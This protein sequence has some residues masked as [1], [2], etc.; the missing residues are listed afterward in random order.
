MSQIERTLTLKR[1][2]TALS[3]CLWRGQLRLGHGVTTRLFTVCPFLYCL[4]FIPRICVFS[5]LR[6]ARRRSCRFS[7]NHEGRAHNPLAVPLA[8]LCARGCVE[9]GPRGTQALAWAQHRCWALEPSTGGARVCR[10]CPEDRTRC[11]WEAG[12]GCRPGMCPSPRQT[13]G[14]CNGSRNLRTTNPPGTEV[15]AEHPL[16]DSS[17]PS[18]GVAAA[19]QRAHRSCPRTGWTPGAPGSSRR[20]VKASPPS[21]PHPPPAASPPAE[22]AAPLLAPPP[23]PEPAKHQAGAKQS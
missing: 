18:H 19:F 10:R 6:E 11:C 2:E 7:G 8:F 15:P 14:G 16:P 5:C 21:P 22:R 4:T 3:G 9:P 20:Q 1:G 17:R 12:P 23:T 13:F